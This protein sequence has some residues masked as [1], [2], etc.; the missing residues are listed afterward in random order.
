[1][2]ILS[3]PPTVGMIR[4]GLLTGVQ[5]VPGFLAFLTTRMLCKV[6]FGSTIR[7]RRQYTL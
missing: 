3:H 4:Y 7:R 5:V 2:Q 1:M 6:V